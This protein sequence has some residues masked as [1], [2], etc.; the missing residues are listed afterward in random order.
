MYERN[1][2]VQIPYLGT[3][4]TEE[5]AMFQGEVLVRWE[6]S[7]EFGGFLFHVEDGHVVCDQDIGHI[8]QRVR[9]VLELVANNYAKEAA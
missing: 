4:H 6:S 2:H 9:L 5:L 7:R 8:S 3:V 1:Q